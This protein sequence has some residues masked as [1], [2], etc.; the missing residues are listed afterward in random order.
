MN[1]PETPLPLAGGAGGGPVPA[2]PAHRTRTRPPLTPPASGRGTRRAAAKPRRRTGSALPTRRPGL[3]A[4]RAGRAL[5][6]PAP[7]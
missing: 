7:C 4:W 6:Q 3:A 1:A 2:N 5:S